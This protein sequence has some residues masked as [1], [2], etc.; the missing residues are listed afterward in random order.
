M[1]QEFMMYILAMYNQPTN[2]GQIY[3]VL[4]GRTT[5]TMLYLVE[6]NSGMV[7]LAYLMT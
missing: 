5:P 2:T 6:K 3:N 1:D 4:I 7:I